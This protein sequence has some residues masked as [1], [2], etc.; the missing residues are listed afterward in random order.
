MFCEGVKYFLLIKIQINYNFFEMRFSGFLLL[1]FCL[2][3][4]K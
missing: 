4:L 2:S 3:L 1:L